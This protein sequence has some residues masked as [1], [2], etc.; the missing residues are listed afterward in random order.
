MTYDEGPSRSPSTMQIA[1]GDGVGYIITLRR[2]IEKRRSQG[3]L[4][5]MPRARD[6]ERRMQASKH[7]RSRRRFIY[8]IFG[9]VVN[10]Q[11]PG[12][13]QRSRIVRYLALPKWSVHANFWEVD[14]SSGP[15]SYQLEWSLRLSDLSVLGVLCSSSCTRSHHRPGHSSIVRCHEAP[16]LQ[17]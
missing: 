17:R 10:V 2:E 5:R 14:N 15:R 3:L 13:E 9:V 11:G 7:L 12:A 4:A 8:T 16:R 1:N 6:V